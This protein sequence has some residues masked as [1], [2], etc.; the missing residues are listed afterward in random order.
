MTEDSMKHTGSRAEVVT[1]CTL[2]TGYRAA[3]DRFA[4]G[5]DRRE[6]PE[7]TYLPLF[8]ALNW[9]VSLLDRLGYPDIELA[10]GLRWAQ[11]IISGPGRLS[12]ETCR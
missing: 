9:A 2:V 11:F 6:S 10:K 8:E 7:A 3:V 1:V 12:H 4:Q 5:V